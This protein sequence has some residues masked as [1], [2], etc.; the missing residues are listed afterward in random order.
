[1]DWPRVVQ[2]TPVTI[3]PR[4]YP[5]YTQL[6]GGKASPA[7]WATEVRSRIL[8]ER[9]FE[10]FGQGE[11]DLAIDW[12]YCPVKRWFGKDFILDIYR[13]SGTTPV[14]MRTMKRRGVCTCP[15]APLPPR[16]P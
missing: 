14:I 16:P 11:F 8:W 7:A 13:I 1:M 9:G 3:G 5:L 12:F 6:T 10:A 15:P 4:E 2:S